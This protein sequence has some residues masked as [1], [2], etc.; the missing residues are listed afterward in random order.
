MPDNLIEY[1]RTH[2]ERGECQCGKCIDKGEDRAPTGHSVSVH[3]FWVQAR[4]NPTAAE[5]RALLEAEYPRVERLREG[6]SYIEIGG[7]IGD[8]G[9]A[10][11]LIGLG[12][13]VGLW[14]VVTP[15]TV[16]FEG[17][18]ADEMAGRGFVMCSGLGP[19]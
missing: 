9:L 10:L 8:Q 4:N 12:E 19:A 15:A 16:F 6:P 17:A 18:E 11:Q 13:L 7:A 1:I 3:F 14:T 2:S 5:L